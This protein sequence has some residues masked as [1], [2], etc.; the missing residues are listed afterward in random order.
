MCTSIVEIVGAEGAGK[1]GEGWFALTHS[2][3]SY[4]HRITRCS[5]RPSR[6]ICQPRARTGRAGRGRADAGGREEPQRSAG[7][8]DHGGGNRGSG[9]VA[10]AVTAVPER[11][12]AK[13]AASDHEAG[14][15]EWRKNGSGRGSHR[16]IGRERLECDDRERILDA[17][18]QLQLLGHEMADIGW[19]P[20]DSTSSAGRTGRRSSRPPDLLDIADRGVRN[21]VGPAEL[22]LTM[23]KMVFIRSPDCTGT[24]HGA[25][26]VAAAL[27]AKQ[28]QARAA[29]FKGRRGKPAGR[30]Q[31]Q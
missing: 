8:R 27:P 3:V 6:S 10:A 22:A 9:A 15:S 20:A 30:R 24:A 5:R 11:R 18:K 1:G 14:V 21:L 25:I 4:D 12:G 28:N 17:R 23:T 16:R 29:I 26:V 2:V 19:N 7:P 13:N 31:S